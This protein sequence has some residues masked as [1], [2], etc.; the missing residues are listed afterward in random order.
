MTDLDSMIV[1]A[2][3][4]ELATLVQ[5]RRKEIAVAL[6]E[7]FAGCRKLEVQQK[8]LDEMNRRIDLLA[9]GV[10]LGVVKGAVVVTV[11][12]PDEGTWKSLRFGTNWFEGIAGLD[13]V[14]LAGLR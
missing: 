2:V 6:R 9:E 12:G 8:Q 11:R 7:A 14:V 3:N 10:S 5:S 4:G 13:D 1:D